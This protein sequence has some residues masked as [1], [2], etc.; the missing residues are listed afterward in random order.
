MMTIEVKRG[1]IVGIEAFSA[2]AQRSFDVDIQ[3]IAST[4]GQLAEETRQI[5]LALG[6]GHGVE[7]L[8]VRSTENI[9]PAVTSRRWPIDQNRGPDNDDLATICGQPLHGLG[10]VAL[11]TRAALRKIGHGKSLIVD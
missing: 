6:I 1:P 10:D 8:A 4:R 2:P 5:G 7:L 11:K 3:N 9:G